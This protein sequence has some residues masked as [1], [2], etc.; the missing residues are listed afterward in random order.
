MDP[1]NGRVFGRLAYV[2][3]DPHK[4][5]QFWFSLSDSARRHHQA[6]PRT[7]VWSPEEPVLALSCGGMHRLS[8]KSHLEQK[9]AF[10][11]REVAGCK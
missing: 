8:M 9:T 11:V 7:R 1:E 10:F 2:D 3:P 5:I 6:C 4:S